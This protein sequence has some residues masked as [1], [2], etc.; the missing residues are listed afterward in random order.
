M[1]TKKCLI[2][3]KKNESSTIQRIEDYMKENYEIRYNEVSN[4]IEFRTIS[5][6]EQN[7]PYSEIN[8]NNI[9]IDLQKAG[10]KA[11]QNSVRAILGSSYVEKYNPIINY[12]KQLPEWDET[13]HIAKLAEYVEVPPNDK[14]R[15]L[16]NFKKMFVRMVASGLGKQLNKQTF[17]IVHNKQN[18]GKS[19]FLRWLCPPDLKAYYTEEMSFD[20]DGAIA[21]TENFMINLDELSVLSKNDINLLKAVMSKDEIKQR[22]PYD[23]RTKVMKRRCNF[24]AST[25]DEE[26]LSDATGNVRW[27]CFK[28]NRIVWNTEPDKPSYNRD[29]DINLVWAQAYSIF[30]KHAL[31]GQLSQS[32]IFENETANKNFLI[33]TP[34]IE[35]MQIHFEPSDK[36][37]PGAE[38]LTATEITQKLNLIAANSIRLF[39]S[40]VGKALKTLGYVIDS[41]RNSEAKFTVKGYW[42][43]KSDIAPHSDNNEDLPEYL[44]L[45]KKELPF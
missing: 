2:M 37:T 25:N 39:P 32:E 18:S 13:D 31:F 19:T 24:V 27:V 23:A 21:L 7:E 22:L 8:D 4:R 15:F 41:K 20:K 40:S 1:P 35:L 11:G 26:F 29:I 42:I 5:D 16:R 3:S 38:F 30:K 9:W 34:E 10:Y 33:R 6:A 45:T 36:D 14:D 28:I 17:V 43:I 12:F 44:S